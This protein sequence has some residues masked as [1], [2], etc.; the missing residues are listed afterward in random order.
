MARV[1]IYRFSSGDTLE[2]R[3]DAIVACFAGKRS[4]LGTAPLNGGRRDDLKWVFNHGGE[5]SGEM[6]APTYE[7]HVAAIAREL[8]LEPEYASGLSTGASVDNVSIKSLSFEDTTVTAVV[9]GGIDVNG[10]RVGEEARWHE[11]GGEITFVAGTINILLFIDARLSEGALA[12][13]LVTCT[14]A[15][16]AAIQ[17]LLAPSCYS[18]G[19][20]T[21]SGTDGT[22]I[23]TNPQSKVRLTEAGKHFKLG[24]LIGKTVM[25]AV[26]EA[27][28]LETGLCPERQMDIIRR[29]SRFG[30]TE[31]ALAARLSAHGLRFEDIAEK[32]AE[33]RKSRQL[34]VKTSCY[35]HILDQLLWGMIKEEDALAAASVLL[36]IM[37]M[38]T[39]EL[40]KCSDAYGSIVNAYI[41][42]LVNL[43]MRK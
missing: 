2:R 35:A 22:I 9:T 7:G 21:G 23:V 17:E 1:V 8:G 29:M 41:N 25:A 43:L 5:S 10:A 28:F 33:I 27:L 26:K 39:R 38:D 20:A 18:S 32:F 19:I 4:V 24:E 11:R 12:R 30:V 6:K 42:G 31:E 37:G 14:E 16:T 34:V 36:A 13:A 40:C 3:G 15:K